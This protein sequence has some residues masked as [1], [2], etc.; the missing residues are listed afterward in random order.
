MLLLLAGKSGFDREW[1]VANAVV[2]HDVSIGAVCNHH[3][4]LFRKWGQ[5]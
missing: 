3:P 4:F 2:V 5:T 1:H